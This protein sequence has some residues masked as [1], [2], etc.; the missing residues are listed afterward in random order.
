MSETGLGLEA[1]GLELS[2]SVT[3]GAAWRVIVEIISMYQDLLRVRADCLGGGRGWWTETRMSSVTS[4]P[5][6]G[7]ATDGRGIGWF[8]TSPA[9]AGW[10]REQEKKSGVGLF[11]PVETGG[12]RWSAEADRLEGDAKGA[13]IDC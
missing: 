8:V 10:G 4:S 13:R 1:W 6:R 9:E 5:T 12:K 7:D 2:V 3:S 11:P